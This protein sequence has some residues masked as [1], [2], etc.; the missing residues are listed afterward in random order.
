VFVF[1]NFVIKIPNFTCQYS[2]GKCGIQANLHERIYNGKHKDFAK[3][4]ASS[5]FGL[6]VIMEYIEPVNNNW[7]REL[8]TYVYNYYINDPL[9][10]WLIS[11]CNPSNWG[12]RD[13]DLIKI[14]FG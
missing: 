14:D 11:D 12:I 10:D 5:R 7:A 13:G 4:Y 8:H 2:H 9:Y 6:W 1:K 3:V